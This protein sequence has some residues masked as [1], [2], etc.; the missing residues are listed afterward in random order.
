[1]LTGVSLSYAAS[2][3]DDTPDRAS[4]Q[5]PIKSEE[6]PTIPLNPKDPTYNL[7]QQRRDDLSKGREP[8]PVNIQRF[9]G[10]GGWHGIP[11]FFKLPV[12]LTPED[13]KAGNVDVAILG[14]HTDMGG[15]YRGAA[16]GPNAMRNSPSTVGWGAFSMPHMHTMVNPFEVLS[17]VDYGDA[18]SDMLSTERTVHAVRELVREI[19]G[20]TTKEGKHVIPIIIGGDHSLMYPATIPMKNPLSGCEKRAFGITPWQR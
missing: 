20:V 19:A 10:G 7:W 18:P 13:L 8:G 1:M 4:E 11:T 3:I 15:G 5:E 17:I 16:W 2:Y 12:A 9:Y 14:A 6:V